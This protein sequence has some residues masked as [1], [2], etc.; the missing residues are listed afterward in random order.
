M[1]SIQNPNRPHRDYLKTLRQGVHTP[2]DEL[3]E[4]RGGCHS[5]DQVE[6]AWV[7]LI[8]LRENAS[9]RF[10]F[11]VWANVEVKS[12]IVVRNVVTGLSILLK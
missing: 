7:G 5:F 11:N 8:M 2:A 9:V 10:I 4:V 1:N 3:L 6:P 12:E